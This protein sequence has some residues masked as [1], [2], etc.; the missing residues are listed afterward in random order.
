ML[1]FVYGT[2]KRGGSNHRYLENQTFVGDACTGPGYRLYAL[3][4]FPGMVAH[5]E[6]REGV[7]GEVWSVDSGCLERLDELEGTTEGLY[8]RERVPLRAP[9]AEQRVEGYL[10]L[11]GV[12]GRREI[13]S[14]WPV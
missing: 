14:V 9:F 6:D 4:G 13:G 11:H 10:Y 8:R 5:N 3:D 2:L 7:R 12:E 1:I